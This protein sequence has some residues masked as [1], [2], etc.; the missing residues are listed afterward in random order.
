MSRIYRTAS[1]CFGGGKG[2]R[3]REGIDDGCF[4]NRFLSLRRVD[5]S[6]LFKWG[7]S[8]LGG[9]PCFLKLLHRIHLNL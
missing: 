7:G 9:L 5:Y 6:G 4:M 3:A 1:F 2:G 8:A